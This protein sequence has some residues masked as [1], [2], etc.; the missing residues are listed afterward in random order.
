MRTAVPSQALDS[1]SVSSG[2]RAE[3]LARFP[4]ANKWPLGI[5]ILVG[6]EPGHYPLLLPWQRLVGMSLSQALGDQF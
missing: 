5:H 2:P 4:T 1:R 3:A 6:R